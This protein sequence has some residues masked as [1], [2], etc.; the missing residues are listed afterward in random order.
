MPTRS[1]TSEVYGQSEDGR[2]GRSQVV[3]HPAGPGGGSVGS[4]CVRGEALG[5]GWRGWVGVTGPKGHPS[6]TA[7]SPGLGVPRWRDSVATG[8][9]LKSG[10]PYSRGC[11]GHAGAGFPMGAGL[12]TPVYLGRPGS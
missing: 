4:R 3:L 10:V 7:T 6:V 9:D 5:R 2:E 12:R 11:G 8:R 1:V